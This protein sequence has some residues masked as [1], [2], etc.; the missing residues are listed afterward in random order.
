M[1]ILGA[2]PQL[3]YKVDPLSIN[4]VFQ[5]IANIINIA[6]YLVGALSVI[7]I[8]VGGLRYSLSGGD[9]KNLAQAK[10]TILYA[11]VGLVLAI[12]SVIIVQFFFNPSGG[13]VFS[14]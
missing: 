6:M 5:L 1:S 12:V 8:I 9:P 11:I 2:F 10:N 13:S 7:F 14:P 4:G 3:W